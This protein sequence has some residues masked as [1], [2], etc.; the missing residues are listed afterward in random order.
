MRNLS[1]VIIWCVGISIVG[2]VSPVY[3]QD[4]AKKIDRIERQL[5]AL[6]RRVFGTNGGNIDAAQQEFGNPAQP[7]QQGSNT[8]RIVADMS[9]KIS[10]VEKQLRILTGRLEE[11][12]YRQRQ[13]EEA[14]E[15][16]QKDTD[17]KIN[18]LKQSNALPRNSNSNRSANNVTD[19]GRTPVNPEPIAPAIELPAG[20]PAVQYDYA[21]SLIRQNDLDSG[22]I[23][24]EKFLA[25]N[26]GDSRTGNAKYWIGR[27]HYLQKRPG[28][29]A[30]SFLKLIEEHPN[31][32]R[33]PDA[34]VDL[35]ETLINLDSSSDACNALAEFERS[36]SGVSNRLRDRAVRVS[37]RAKCS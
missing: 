2:G 27:I 32:P 5:R 19:A 10:A 6:Q 24:M 34:L 8:T 11:L 20:D 18:D 1:F 14:L 25:A 31:H 7:A 9:V 13:L 30:Q 35:A 29:A 21:F 22:L 36:A 17:L 16:V 12:E 26:P 15:A 3:G 28:Q 37:G 23:A 4:T 33:R